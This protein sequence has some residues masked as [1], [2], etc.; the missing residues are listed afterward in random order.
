MLVLQP[1]GHRFNVG[2]LFALAGAV[3]LAV[4]M[5]TVRWLGATEPVTRVLFYYFLLATRDGHSHRRDRLAT[6]S[7][8]PGFG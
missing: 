7:R 1:Q 5:M 8:R 2:E 4:A 6:V 3:L